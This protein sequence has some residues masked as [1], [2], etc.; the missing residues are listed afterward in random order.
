LIIGFIVVLFESLRGIKVT[1]EK[2]KDV[3]IKEKSS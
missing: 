2:G 1:P 3:I